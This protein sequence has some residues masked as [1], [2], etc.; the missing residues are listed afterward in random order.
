MVTKEDIYK[1]VEAYGAEID[2]VKIY[3]NEADL[4]GKFD[5]ELLKMIIEYLE[6]GNV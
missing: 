6:K 4:Y 1:R 3:N 5:L 2:H